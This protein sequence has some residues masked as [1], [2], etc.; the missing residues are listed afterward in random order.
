MRDRVLTYLIVDAM[1]EMTYQAISKYFTH[2]SN[3]GYFNQSNVNKLLLLTFIQELVDYDFRGLISEED[4]NDIN[5]ALYCLYGSSC[6]IPYPDY[7]NT[8]RRR[9]MYIGSISELT[10]RVEALEEAVE[11][12]GGGGGGSIIDK[13]IIVPSS[14][15]DDEEIT[16]GDSP[17]APATPVVDGDNEE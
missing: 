12:G 8:K 4:Y 14:I 15:E 9:T 11:Q 17:D 7:Y 13:A 3:V 1:D 2:L 5:K 16:N 6:L 10:H